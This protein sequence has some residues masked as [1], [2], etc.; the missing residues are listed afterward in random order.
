MGVDLLHALPP[1]FG[2]AALHQFKSS[3]GDNNEPDEGFEYSEDVGRWAR[4]SEQEI[5]DE[6]TR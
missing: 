1:A 5:E 2:S 3:E 4:G 6:V